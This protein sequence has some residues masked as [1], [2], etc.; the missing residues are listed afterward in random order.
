MEVPNLGVTSDLQLQPLAQPQQYWIWATSVT[1]CSLWQCQCLSHWARLGTKPTLSRRL[2]YLLTLLSHHGNSPL[3]TYVRANDLNSFLC[4]LSTQKEN[5]QHLLSG[6]RSM[7]TY[8]TL[9]ISAKYLPSKELK[10][11]TVWS[12]CFL[13]HCTKVPGGECDRFW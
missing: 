5:G 3:I 9:L 7:N 6:N 2:H 10:V 8:K 11:V 13:N 4:L 12:S 1:Y